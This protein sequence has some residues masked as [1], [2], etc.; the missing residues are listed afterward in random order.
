MEIKIDGQT[1]VLTSAQTA[2]FK[3]A[4]LKETSV[5]DPQ[6]CGNYTLHCKK[7]KGN[8]PFVMSTSVPAPINWGIGEKRYGKDFSLQELKTFIQNL[9]KYAAQIW[10]TA[11][12]ELKNV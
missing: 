10:T 5:P 11:E 12:K 6:S 8:Y 7:A 1:I 9:K 3:K 2:Q 4:V